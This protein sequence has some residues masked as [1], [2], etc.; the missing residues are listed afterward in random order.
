M[1][2]RFAQ[3]CYSDLK[4]IVIGGLTNLVGDAV[5]WGVE[6]FFNQGN[7]AYGDFNCGS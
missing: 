5:S 2:A 1:K 3:L 4:S 7:N 6:W